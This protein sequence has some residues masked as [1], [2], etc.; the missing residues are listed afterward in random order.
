MNA[1][2]AARVGDSPEKSAPP[3]AFSREAAFLFALGSGVVGA[4]SPLYDTYVPSWVDGHLHDASKVGA[5]MGID[6]LLLLCVVPFVGA[7]SDRVRTR[8]GRRLPFAL[9]ALP[10]AACGLAALPFLDRIGFAPFLFGIVAFNLALAVWRAPFSAL[11]AELIPS[12]KRSL[13]GGFSAAAMCVGAMVMLGPPGQMLYQR[14]PAYPFL[15]ASSLMLAVWSAHLFR[16]REPESLAEPSSAEREESPLVALRSAFAA[17]HG[18]AVWFF[19]ACVSFH[20]A[21]QSFSGWFTKHA[22]ERFTADDGSALTIAA[23]GT[24]FLVVA[25]STLLGSIPAGYL[26]TRFGRRRIAV[27]GISGMLISALAMH[28]APDFRTACFL[29]VGFGLSWSLPTANLMAMAFE[30]LPAARAGT[31]A[32]V[33]MFCQGVA[34]SIGPWL[35]GMAFDEMESKRTLFLWIAGFLAVALVAMASLRPGFGEA[36]DTATPTS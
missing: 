25:V 4:S 21:F 34:G 35:V 2:R 36:R 1:T 31:L 11:L 20:L 8:L 6:N 3:L 7:W 28:V 17:E 24:G 10:I 12:R 30:L 15:L 14:D 19:L 29:L 27:I 33:L 5:V 13:V 18:K 26:G 16:L 23:A 22:S 32:G 9:A